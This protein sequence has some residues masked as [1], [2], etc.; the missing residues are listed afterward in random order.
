MQL[1]TAE[2][3]RKFILSNHIYPGAKQIQVISNLYFEA[4]NTAIIQLLQKYHDKILI[5]ISGHD[6]ISDLRYNLGKFI[7]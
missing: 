2:K 5:E 6:H 7:P 4:N 1:Y 3:D